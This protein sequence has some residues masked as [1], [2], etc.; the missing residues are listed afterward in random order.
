MR[1][2]GA[3]HF[4]RPR[5]IAPLSAFLLRHH[6]PGSRELGGVATRTR[7]CGR[8]VLS[9]TDRLLRREGERD[10]ARSVGGDSHRAEEGLALVG[11]L[12]V[13]KELD[14]EGLVGAAVE[15][16]PDGRGA[17]GALLCGGEGRLVLQVVGSGVGIAGIVGSEAVGAQVYAEVSVGKDGVGEDAV[18]R[19]TV[20]IDRHTF[21]G[22]AA[23]CRDD[24]T[25]TSFRTTDGVVR[26]AAD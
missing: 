19:G 26:S 18:A 16:A 7:G 11:A 6:L 22:P 1:V 25:H 13:G 14:V 8:Y 20:A 12:R 17:R 4:P 21:V 2:P 5:S 15:G 10:V 3:R 23:I 9:Q 24:V